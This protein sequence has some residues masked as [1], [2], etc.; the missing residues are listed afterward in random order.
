MSKKGWENKLPPFFLVSDRSTG[1]CQF[2]IWLRGGNPAG[3]GTS[4]SASAV[5]FGDWPVKGIIALT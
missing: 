5:V 4:A 3:G 1:G 2:E